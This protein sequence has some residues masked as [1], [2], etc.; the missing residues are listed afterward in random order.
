MKYVII[1]IIIKSPEFLSTIV[2]KHLTIHND[3][4]FLR[5]YSNSTVFKILKHCATN[6]NFTVDIVTM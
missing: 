5:G 6:A 1:Y 3:D 2:D 4:L